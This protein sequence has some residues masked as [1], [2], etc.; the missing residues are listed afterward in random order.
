MKRRYF[1]SLCALFGCGVG[2]VLYPARSTNTLFKVL[3]GLNL[4][5][6]SKVIEHNYDVE[7]WLTS[8]PLHLN[9]GQLSAY[10][11]DNIM[12]DY[13]RNDLDIVGE[14]VVSKTEIMIYLAK[15]SY[16]PGFR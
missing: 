9:E 11:L 4:P 10:L 7:A 12:K 6:S 3:D 8:L 15:L 2:G 5:F 14:V 16:A 1:L 13:M